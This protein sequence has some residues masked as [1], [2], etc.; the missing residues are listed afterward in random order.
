MLKNV[1]LILFDPFSEVNSYE[2]KYS[3]VNLSNLNQALISFKNSAS[4]YYTL[5]FLMLFSYY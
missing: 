1:L 4:N 3:G 5:F 2:I